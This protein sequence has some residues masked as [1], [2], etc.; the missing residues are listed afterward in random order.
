MSYEF[1]TI[2]VVLNAIATVMLWERMRRAAQKPPT[3]NKK[4]KDTIWKGDPIT[5]KHDRAK[6]IS[7][8]RN[9]VSEGDHRFF[10]DFAEFGDVVNWWLADKHVGSSWRLQELSNTNLRLTFSDSPEFGRRYDIFYNQARLGTLEVS[11]GYDSHGN[12]Y[13]IETANV[14]T[15]ISLGMIRLLHF[16]EI[17]EFLNAIAF[18]VTDCTDGSVEQLKT[19]QSFRTAMTKVLWYGQQISEYEDLDG[20]DLGDLSLT[21]YGNPSFYFRRRKAPAFTARG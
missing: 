12:A 4:F 3:P 15:D 11:A 16:D 2:I 7:E 18:H 1:L 8:F 9:L 13:S 10:A 17:T 21:L 20:Q 19:Q 6:S 14:R 5:P